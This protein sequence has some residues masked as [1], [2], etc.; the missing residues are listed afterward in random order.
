[1]RVLVAAVLPLVLAAC[2]AV[3]PVPETAGVDAVLLGE[4]HDADAH[5]GIQERWVSA[6]ARRGSLGAVTLEMAER[7]TST[8]GLPTT[9]SDAQVRDALRWNQGT[10]WSWERYGPAIMAAVRAG[11]PV[12]GANLTR[13]QMRAAMKDESL[14]RLLPGPAVKAQQQAI[15]EGHCDMLPE[16]QIQPM[17]RVQIARDVSMASTISSSVAPGKTVVLIAGSGHVMPDVGVPR[18]LPSTVVA[19]SLVLPKQETGKD[20]CEEFRQQR[21]QHRQKPMPRAAG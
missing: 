4:Q 7:G 1:M 2:S 20:Y 18:H 11:V 9:A 14:D 17:T 12:L 15:R 19:R 21:E 3:P 5:P 16:T 8:A 6:L 13:E 10:G